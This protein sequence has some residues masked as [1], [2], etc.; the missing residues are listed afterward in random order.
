M[1]QEN[2]KIILNLKIF[3]SKIESKQNNNKNI[4]S[5]DDRHHDDDD[6]GNNVPFPIPKTIFLFSFFFIS[7]NDDNILTE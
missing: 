2:V 1:N 5:N 6:D 4:L 7:F 3:F